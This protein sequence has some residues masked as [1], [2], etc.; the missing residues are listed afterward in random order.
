[1]SAWAPLLPAALVGTERHAAPLPAWPGEVGAAIAAAT[2]GAEPAAAVLRAAAV[3]AACSAAGAQGAPLADVLPAGAMADTQDALTEPAQLAPITWALREGPPRL[4][5]AVALVL[6]RA[7]LRVPP[8]LLPTVLELG[9]RSLA[10]RA[11]FAPTLG[12]RGRWL[13]Q[14]REEWRYAAGASTEADAQTLWQ[15]GSFEQRRALLRRERASDPAAAR[16][17]LQQALPELPAK[18]RAELVAVLAEGIGP[19]DE[20]LLDSLR[21]DRS[22]EVRQAALALLLHLPEAAHPRRAAARLAAFVTSQRGLLGRRW[23]IDAPS[24]ATDDWKADQIEATRPTHERLGE[25]A[26]WLYQLVRQVPLAWWTMHTGLDAAELL[27]WAAKTDWAEALQRGWRDVLLAAPDLT[28][29]EAVL[30]SGAAAWAEHHTQLLALL[31]P[32]RRERH[33]QRQLKDSSVRLDGLL[34][35]ILAA[36]PAG[37]TLSAALS[38]ALVQHVVARDAAATLAGDYTLRAALPEL[39]AALHLETLAPLASI[40]RRPDDTPSWADTLHALA[41]TLATRR[42]LNTLAPETATP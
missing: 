24:A 2:A 1:M 28:W 35:Q 19:D 37:Q 27:K 5:Q 21:S 40:Q 39:A 7:G 25:R 17:R 22:R 16:E 23:E 13:G 8:A 38:T 15:D 30:D 34:L 3:L 41:Q 14:Q 10:L 11:A 36:C 18:E 42:A 29:C 6:G 9:R 20:S 12:E 26:W 33:W 4:Q 32:A 31:P